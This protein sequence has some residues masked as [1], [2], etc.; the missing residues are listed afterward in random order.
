M[1]EGPLAVRERVRV[2]KFRFALGSASNVRY[3]RG[4]LHRMAR[5]VKL[6]IGVGGQSSAV[7]IDRSVAKAGD[8][9]AVRM[10]AVDEIALALASQRMFGGCQFVGDRG[11]VS[12][13]NGKH[14]AHGASVFDG[15]WFRI[16]TA[17]GTPGNA[18]SSR[19][20]ASASLFGIFEDSVLCMGVFEQALFAIALKRAS[21]LEGKALPRQASWLSCEMNATL[22]GKIR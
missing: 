4:R 17:Y 1:G 19:R 9:P 5:T 20:Q 7:K 12:R 3:H 16:P 2:G 11:C 10:I 13:A 21:V 14:A 8:A 15:R 22:R 18:I 6:L